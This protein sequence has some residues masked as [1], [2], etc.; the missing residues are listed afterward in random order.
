MLRSAPQFWKKKTAISHALLPFSLLYHAGTLLRSAMSAPEDAD[1]PVICV[2][3]AVAGGAGKTPAALYVAEILRACGKRPFFLTRG[4]GGS[5]K[6]PV[7]VDAA[8]HTAKEVGDEPLL[9]ARSCPTVV[10]RNR[11]QGA[12]FAA[13]AGADVIVM[14]DG[15]QNPHLHK[16]FSLLVV[17]GV[18]RFG[19]GRMLPAGPLREPVESALLR[20]DAV[21]VIDG[22]LEAGHTPV[23]HGTLMTGEQE[24]M[25]KDKRVIGFAGIAHPEKFLRTLEKIGCKVV[26]FLHFP[27]HHPYTDTELGALV[28]RAD[29]E[30]ATL[31][32]TAKDWVRIPAL[33]QGKIKAVEVKLL[34]TETQ[35]LSAL[36]LKSV[37]I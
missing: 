35:Q 8:R 1:V 11:V 12:A 36:I 21:M 2:G 7:L 16:N 27:D 31:L 32:T 33:L 17:D 4:Y 15:F 34:V 3:N 23:F 19:N 22:D 14:D 25:L 5:E 6:G 18:Y 13:A 24:A 26:D 37:G 10:S 28:E 9:L 20:A 29:A 30:G